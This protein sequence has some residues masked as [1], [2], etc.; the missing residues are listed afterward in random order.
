MKTSLVASA[1]I[2]FFSIA[3]LSKNKVVK[4]ILGGAG[5]IVIVLGITGILG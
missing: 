4:G 1:I 3:G 2:V 5:V